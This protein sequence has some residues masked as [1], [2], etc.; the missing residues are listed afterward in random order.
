MI[1]SAEIALAQ[2]RAPASRS[3]EGAQGTVTG[4]VADSSSGALLPGATV[5]IWNAADSTLA[6]GAIAGR[7]GRF[8]IVGLGPGRY[9]AR[10]SYVGYAVRVISGIMI[11]PGAQEAD[12]GRVALR[13]NAARNDE[14]V[15]TAERDFMTVEADRTVYK[16]SDLTVSAGGNATDVLRNIPSV[17][18]DADDKVSLR[19]NQNVAIQVN[20]RPMILQ[21]DALTNFLRGLPAGSVE[22]IEVVTNPSVKY[23]PEGMG[24]II[25]IVLDQR[26]SRGFSGGVNGAISTTNSQ[27]IGVNMAYGDGPWNVFGSYAL[28]HGNRDGSGT[29]YRENRV[30]GLT[31]ILEQRSE[32][33]RNS[34]SHSLN[35]SADYS[36]GSAGTFSLSAVVNSRA[37]DGRST[38]A[39]T[40][41]ATDRA[42][43]R[44]YDRDAESRDDETSMDYRLGYKL[45]LEPSKHEL[46]AEVRYGRENELDQTDYTQNDFSLDGSPRDSLR[47]LQ[48]TA[49]DRKFNEYSMQVDYVRPLVVPGSRLETGYQGKVEQI[50]GDYFSESLDPAA[51]EFR[52]DMALNNTYE[53]K[54]QIHAVYGTYG[55][56]FGDFSTQIGVRVEGAYTTFDLLTSGEQFENDYISVF[57]SAFLNYKPSDAL[58]FKASYGRRVQRPRIRS[59]NPFIT[60]SDPQFRNAGN[61][62]L[63]PEYTDSYEVSGVFFGEGIT[64][65]ATP[66][67]RRST[68]VIRRFEVIDSSGISTSTFVNFD[69]NQSYGLDLVGTIRPTD[70]IRAF[71]SVSAYRSVTDANNVEA[72]LGSDGIS[73]SARANATCMLPEG[74]DVQASYFY[75]AP[76]KVEGG[77]MKAMQMMD[78]TVQK[79]FFN[80]K[81]RVGLRASDPFKLRGF[82][83]I[84]NDPRYYQESRRVWESGGYFLTFS[85]TF[86]TSDR[87][88]RRT[89]DGQGAPS[90]DMEDFGM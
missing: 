51:G 62:H 53:Y 76:M 82:G 70:W 80:D 60:Y 64:L 15:V 47:Q 18:V 48:R 16:T 63:K 39:T 42:F 41:L 73:W 88:S 34:L 8:S 30:P 33:N 22:R 55:Q 56:E 32:N 2:G 4:I 78:F 58:Q 61:P 86:G 40:E 13:V 79:K 50:G 81:A 21:G 19:G 44:R 6:T 38:S 27:N 17:E 31:P 23:D 25:N 57:P 65:T 14:I 37:A 75:R 49:E 89:R 36:L 7:D 24:G 59:L 77:E 52:P 45:V 20:G 12:L 67:Y 72:D 28:N 90:E 69:V 84:R 85:Y 83:M 29:R 87:S 10:V 46:S 26:T 68:D 3:G 43:L 54:R 5:A 11:R 35:T 71:A 1:A 66:F 74:I 9:Y